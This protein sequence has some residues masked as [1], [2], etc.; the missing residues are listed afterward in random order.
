MAYLSQIDSVM[1]IYNL[2]TLQQYRTMPELHNHPLQ[3]IQLSQDGKYI[4][5]TSESGTVI[6]IVPV[7]ETLLDRY[8]LRRAVQPTKIL[9]LSFDNT[10]NLL[11][12]S[13]RQGT[14]HIFDRL[15]GLERPNQSKS[16]FLGDWILGE[17][18]R[19]FATIKLPLE[20]TNIVAFSEDSK[21]VYTIT[22]E[23]KFSQWLITQKSQSWINSNTLCKL[24]Q[25]YSLV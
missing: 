12:L 5:T 25:E 18:A 24:I 4:A 19:S 16:T 22:E 6:K 9:S 8:K 13:S 17:E 23:G 7:Q 11:A 1:V 20:M 2:L 21:F 15:S 14:V 3:L 10:T